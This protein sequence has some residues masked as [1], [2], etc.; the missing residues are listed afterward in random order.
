MLAGLTLWGSA[1]VAFVLA[2]SRFSTPAHKL[3][4]Y[5]LF[6]V[7]CL[8]PWTLW[9]LRYAVRTGTVTA[10][11]AVVQSCVVMAV[12][13]PVHIVSTHRLFW[14]YFQDRDTLLGIRLAGVPFEEYLFYPLTINFAILLYLLTCEHMRTRGLPDLAVNRK[15][16][17]RFLFGLAAIFFAAAVYV[18]S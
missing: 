3:P 9:L 17:R 15:W 11:S 13:Y 14:G 2:I 7:C 16:L 6:E 5:F 8:I 12:T 18:W 4:G 1:Y 10:V